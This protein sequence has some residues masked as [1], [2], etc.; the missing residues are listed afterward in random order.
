MRTK[1]FEDGNLFQFRYVGREVEY[2]N[3]GHI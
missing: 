1:N 2:G 3:C